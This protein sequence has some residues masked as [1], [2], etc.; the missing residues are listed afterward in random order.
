MRD[1]DFS[2]L[3]DL[4]SIYPRLLP[5]GVVAQFAGALHQKLGL[6][7]THGLFPYTSPDVFALSQQVGFS[8]HLK[9][10]K[11][12]PED[13][14]FKVVDVNAVRIYAVIVPKPKQMGVAGVWQNYGVGIGTRLSEALLPHV[15]SLT[16]VPFEV[17]G[18]G[19]V[20]VDKVPAPTYLPE[21]EAHQKLRE[22]ISALL[23]RAPLDP[24]RVKYTPDDVY[25]YTSGMAAISRTHE[26]ITKVRKG[27]V[28]VLGSVFHNTF[29]LFEESP[30]GFKHFG[31]CDAK[32]G[33]LDKLEAYVQA[34]EKEGRKIAYVFVEFPSN[35]ILVSVDLQRLKELA[36]KYDF[37]AV[38]DDTIAS[39][40]NVDLTSV[41][42]VIITSTTKSFSGYADLMGGSV[43]LNPDSPRYQQ[44][45][46]AFKSLYHNEYFAGDAEKLLS[47]SED[48]LVRSATYNRN[49][50]A[51]AA[52]LQTQAEDPA[53]PVV[54]VQYPQQ[55]DTLANYQAFMRP[56]TAEFTP[57]YGCLLS[58]ELENK[59]Q[60]K[61]FFNNLSFHAGPHLGAHLSL[62]LPFN[63]MIW[64]G[65][66]KDREY[67]EG[68]GAK[69]TQ[70]RISVGLESEEEL[71]DTVKAAV[72]AAKGASPAQ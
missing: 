8:E 51:L 27:K 47:N 49:A 21:V 17:A 67:H 36:D 52:Y 34:E 61:T 63:E 56:A 38:I 35:P 48:Y 46:E 7:E 5:F 20:A 37:C 71:V 15:Q 55:T 11:L 43:V 9:E 33:V 26:A 16:E 18:D 3:M 64:G 31:E 53:S 25:L 1:R 30:C 70:I 13:L 24:L 58:V 59:E 4:K 32:S 42:D 62:A 57:G 29:H 14:T 69:T 68:Y 39:F 28:V 12:A 19:D 40:C 6:P 41:A 60:T 65:Q 22:R 23:G 44:L 2:L 45:K 54:S 50:S 72:E 10:N 66:P